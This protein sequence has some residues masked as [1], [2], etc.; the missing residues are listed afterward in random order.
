MD[1]FEELLRENLPVLQRFVFFRIDHRFDAEDILQE[2]CAA[3]SAN[4]NAL[5]N[6]AAFK[7][8]LLAIARNKCADYFRAKAKSPEI[9]VEVLPE[10]P[11]TRSL[12][13]RTEDSAVRETLE[14]L[15]KADRQILGLA[16][17]RNWPQA[18]I[19]ETL[20]IPLGTVKSRLHHA[21]ERFREQYPYPSTKSTKKEEKAMKKLPDIIPEYT[22]TPLDQPPFPVRWEE[23]M[24][25]FLVP[26]I[27][28]KLTWAMYDFPEKTRTEM[29]A[30]EVTGPAEVHGI[31][32][33]EIKAVETSPMD[34]NSA[35]GQEEVTR[36]FVAQL[37]DT[38]CRLL[39]ESHMED[40]VRRLYTFL[41]GDAFL[42]N[43]GFGEDNCGNEINLFPKGDIVREGNTVT[44]K[45]KPFLLDVTGRYTV[46]I[47]GNTYDTV[48]VTDCYTYNDG[49]VSEQYL[50][51]NGRTILWRR[52]NRDDWHVIPGGKLWSERLP[53]NERIV[54][55]GVTYVHWYDCI[56]DYIL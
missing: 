15:S 41:D 11:D 32:G 47:N 40:G 38:Y 39:A 43:W 29:C 4:R 2:T 51:R 28:E 20:R 54:V 1:T 55:N 33:V 16:Y 18:K 22:I 14:K 50:D 48:C 10:R 56:T 27:G 24:G 3:A 31:R 25:W 53:D 44:A 46:T 21:R 49:V 52:F 17:F 9:P 37:T 19:A 13:G 35:G 45:E 36:H 5:H 23:L 42:D 34:C 8:W 6:P 26:R 30:M 12:S 7:G